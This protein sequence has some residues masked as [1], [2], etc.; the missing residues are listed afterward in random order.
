MGGSSGAPQATQSS[1]E[2][3]SAATS[4]TSK[5]DVMLQYVVLR[6]DLW[7]ELKWP[8]GSI[9]AQACHAAT[10]ALWLTREEDVTQAYC[11]EGN[12]DHMHKVSLKLE[13]SYAYVTCMIDCPALE[14][15]SPGGSRE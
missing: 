9:V 5:D 11:S 4:Q 12:L 6:R 14:W 10:A 7:K 8:L 2:A 13:D 1:A 3:T 15:S